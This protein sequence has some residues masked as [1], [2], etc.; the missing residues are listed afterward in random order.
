LS[1]VNF[2]ERKNAQNKGRDRRSQKSEPR[3]LQMQPTQM[4]G[5]TNNS[6]R[7]Q[8]TK[9]C[10]RTDQKRQYVDRHYSP[11]NSKSD[12]READS[13]TGPIAHG[14]LDVIGNSCVVNYQP[15]GTIQDAGELKSTAIIA[16]P[17]RR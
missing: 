7:R 4:C 16:V 9:S 6:S 11:V 17:L 1:V 10:H 2:G 3:A 12:C 14:A 5:P 15:D 8:G 13:I